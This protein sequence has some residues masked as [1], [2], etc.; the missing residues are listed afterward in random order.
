MATNFRPLEASERALLERLLQGEFP[1]RDALSNQLHG[2]S[3]RTIDEYGSLELRVGE[4]AAPAKLSPSE[5]DPSRMLTDRVPV[6]GQY[7]DEDGIPVC[8]ML[9]VVEGFIHELQ[10]FKADGSRII[11][12]PTPESVVLSTPR[13]GTIVPPPRR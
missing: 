10:I 13:V 9:H 8:V 1:R 6:E 7:R 4:N 2:V 11:N 3:V 12:A 5:G